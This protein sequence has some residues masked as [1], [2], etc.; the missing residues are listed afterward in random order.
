[1]KL[2]LY[3][4]TGDILE[5]IKNCGEVSFDTGTKTLKYRGGEL[6]PYT[7]RYAVLNDDEEV[8]AEAILEHYKQERI[9][10]FNQLCE[11]AIKA[12]FEHNGRW[13]GFDEHDQDN[14]TQMYLLLISRPEV[15]QEPIRWKTKNAGVVELTHE[16]FIEVCLAAENHKR[17]LIEKYWGL[18]EQIKTAGTF[19]ELKSMRWEA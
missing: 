4:D 8:T 9:E 16:E 7:G 19:L 10:E 6:W 15:V 1:M 18:E 13:Y 5:V 17:R 3:S 14:F 11:A 2:V 12:G